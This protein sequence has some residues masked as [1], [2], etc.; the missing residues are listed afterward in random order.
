MI[1]IWRNISALIMLSILNN[2]G[3]K[4]VFQMTHTEVKPPY[5]CDYITEIFILELN[6]LTQLRAETT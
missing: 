5:S 4:K 6:F 1:V 3:V 2:P